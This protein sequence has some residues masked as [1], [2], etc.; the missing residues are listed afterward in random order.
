M[1]IKIFGSYLAQFSVEA[2]KI[3]LILFPTFFVFYFMSALTC[4]P[5]EQIAIY[6]WQELWTLWLVSASTQNFGIT[7]Y[8]CCKGRCKKPFQAQFWNNEFTPKP[9]NCTLKGWSSSICRV[10]NLGKTELMWTSAMSQ[11]F[12]SVV[13]CNYNKWWKKSMAAQVILQIRPSHVPLSGRFVV[14]K[15]KNDC[16]LHAEITLRLVVKTERQ[17]AD[18]LQRP[19]MYLFPLMTPHGLLCS[20]TM[21]LYDS[22]TG[23]WLS[24]FYRL[25]N[26]PFSSQICFHTFKFYILLV[27]L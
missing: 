21:H 13:I 27:N 7:N 10:H 3:W 22:Q 19:C 17:L 12:F 18:V 5:S 14:W 9:T 23:I 1:K 24:K 16:F 4:R 20:K 25:K 8:I 11:D 2:S 6:I 26:N 15:N